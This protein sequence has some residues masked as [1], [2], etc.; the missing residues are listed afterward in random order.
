M[1]LLGLG[2]V[3]MSAHA[4]LL[5]AITASP[6]AA[7]VGEP[8]TVT[9]NID[10]VGGNYC[11]FVVGF[12]DGTSQDGVSDSSTKVPLVV[13]HTYTKPG[14]YH[15]TLGGRNVQNHPNCAG[16]ERA[17]DITV[18][19]VDMPAAKPAAMAPAAAPKAT[20]APVAPTAATVCP[21]G[22]KLVAKSF[23]A[24][25]GAFSCAAKPGMALPAAKP[26]CQGDLTYFENAKKGQLG[27]RP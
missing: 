11:G 18:A 1:A 6:M 4:Q 9:A 2:V 24:K 22:W 17:V 7:K 5:G 27:C 21:A 20:A 26:S 23:K 14:T 13:Q 8:V 16:P 3:A 25:T 12:G 10:V 19:G 15:I